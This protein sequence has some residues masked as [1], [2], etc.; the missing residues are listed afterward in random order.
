MHDERGRLLTRTQNISDPATYITPI[1]FSI[2]RCASDLSRRIAATFELQHDEKIFGCGESFTRFNKRGQKVLVS[3][4]DGMGTQNEYMYK[5]I[6][7]FLS[8]NGYGMF[9]HTSAA[10]P[11]KSKNMLGS[12][13]YHL[14]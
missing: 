11:Q 5:P 14:R 3:T 1:P 4:H 9:V 13:Q 2:V 8:S 12:G 10:L 7:F 6:P